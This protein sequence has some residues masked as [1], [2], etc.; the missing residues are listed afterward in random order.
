MKTHHPPTC[1]RKPT[2]GETPRHWGDVATVLSTASCISAFCAL[3]S[4]KSVSSQKICDI[5]LTRF[6]RGR[7]VAS[8]VRVA[9][10]ASNMPQRSK[11]WIQLIYAT[12][13]V[14]R[15]KIQEQT[16]EVSR[17]AFKLKHPTYLI[18]DLPS[19]FHLAISC[20]PAALSVPHPQLL[21]DVP[22][23]RE[24]SR[25]PIPRLRRTLP[26]PHVDPPRHVKSG[27]MVL[28][29]GIL[30]SSK[31]APKSLKC[32]SEVATVLGKQKYRCARLP[33]SWPYLRH[34]VHSGLVVQGQQ[35]VP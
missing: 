30:N 19:I 2:D 14:L 26:S 8:W 15:P 17:A 25:G 3:V 35:E 18:I 31:S 1:T 29:C 23:V 7:H 13:A 12:P 16:A 27:W 11:R 4:K 32:F 28:E 5:T 34:T 22:K 6:Q 20:P 33:D 21:H 9:S 10:L 24:N